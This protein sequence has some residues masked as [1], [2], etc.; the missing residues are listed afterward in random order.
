MN[1]KPTWNPAAPHASLMKWGESLRK[2]AK[3]VFLQD[4]THAQMLFLFDDNGIAS[5]NPIPPRTNPEQ[6]AAGVR[7]AIGEH[8]LYGVITIAEAWTY[9]PEKANDHTVS[10]LLDGEMKVSD[11]RE[12]DK[13]E[14]L[15]VSL[16]S[17]DGEHVTW[18]DKIERKDGKVTLGLGMRVPKTKCLKMINFFEND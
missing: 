13:T 4:G 3:R 8:N 7:H 16:Q 15:M 11:L 17:R 10:Q 2:E 6:I 18:L 1:D 5:V 12:G 14:V 9:F